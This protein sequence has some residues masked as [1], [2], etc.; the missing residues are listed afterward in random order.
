MAICGSLSSASQKY[1]LA[2]ADAHLVH[3]EH[4]KIDANYNTY[5]FTTPHI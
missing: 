1:C 5:K 2:W 4:L 3:R